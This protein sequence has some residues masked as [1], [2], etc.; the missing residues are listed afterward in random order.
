MVLPG[1][2]AALPLRDRGGAASILVLWVA[3]PVAAVLILVLLALQL[4]APVVTKGGVLKPGRGLTGGVNDSSE[5]ATGS[6][7]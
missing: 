7:N 2:A 5:K 4:T 3:L 6:G 1:S